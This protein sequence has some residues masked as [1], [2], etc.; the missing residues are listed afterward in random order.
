MQQPTSFRLE[1]Y[2]LPTVF[3]S[4]ELITSLAQYSET[5]Q[6][7]PIQIEDEKPSISRK[8]TAKRASDELSSTLFL[9]VFA[10]A[11][12]Y[13]TNKTIM[14]DV[15]PVFVDIILDPFIF[16]VFPRSLVPTAGYIFLLAIGGW[17][18]AK[19]ISTWFGN[20]VRE[21]LAEDRK[22]K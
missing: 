9:Q 21:D 6:P 5:R 15:P 13:T 18:L 2:D 20:L 4:P 3:E 1:A 7:D 12:Y 8:Q 10:A 11:D 16:N 22:K 17:F 19:Y 14:K